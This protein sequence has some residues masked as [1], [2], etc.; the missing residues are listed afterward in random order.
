M[1]RRA[2]AGGYLRVV[3]MLPLRTIFSACRHLEW[4]EKSH[5]SGDSA[6]KTIVLAG[7]YAVSANFYHPKNFP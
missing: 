1:W 2:P 6:Q 7:F 4:L 5:F 3:P